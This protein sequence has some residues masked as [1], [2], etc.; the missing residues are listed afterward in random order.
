M[1]TINNVR[2]FLYVSF[3]FG[4]LLFLL[5][6][7]LGCNQD[8]TTSIEGPTQTIKT[9]MLPG[10]V[11][12]SYAIYSKTLATGETVRGFVEI[13]GKESGEEDYEGLEWSYAW[14]FKVLGPMGE[15]VLPDFN[16]SWP[17]DKQ[18][19]FNFVATSVGTYKIIVGHV[20]NNVMMLV[21]EIEP[22]GWKYSKP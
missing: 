22:S 18:H 21:G 14:S 17:N 3:C 1:K 5:V 9:S 10:A 6:S 8:N 4:L 13:A 19:E 15:S 12:V 2:E 11:N 16:G 20:S 7:T